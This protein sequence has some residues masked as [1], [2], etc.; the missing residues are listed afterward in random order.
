VLL[1]ALLVGEV[2]FSDSCQF[3]EFRFQGSEHV[4]GSGVQVFICHTDAKLVPSEVHIWKCRLASVGRP[5][6]SDNLHSYFAKSGKKFCRSLSLTKSS[7]VC[8]HKILL[9][10]LRSPGIPL[11]P[12]EFW[13]RPPFACV[14]CFSWEFRNVCHEKVLSRNTS[15]WHE[16]QVGNQLLNRLNISDTSSAFNFPPFFPENDEVSVMFEHL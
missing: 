9:S 1:I 13:M 15:N 8:N 3:L 10:L 11:G 16:C 2:A 14:F 5:K 7:Q 12:V 4:E 6:H